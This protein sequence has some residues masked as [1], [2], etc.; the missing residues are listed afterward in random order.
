MGAQKH[1]QDAVAWAGASLSFDI[2]RRVHVFELT[3]RALGGLLSAHAL[4]AAGRGTARTTR[5]AIARAASDLATIANVAATQ[6][7]FLRRLGLKGA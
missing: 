2:D 1:L 4:L 5:L 3:I 7:R 6:G